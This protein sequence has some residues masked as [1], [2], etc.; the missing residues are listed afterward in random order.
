VL[1]AAAGYAVAAV[2]LG[3]SL[4]WTAQAVA[5]SALAGVASAAGSVALAT[6]LLPVAEE[7]AGIDT[8]LKLLEWSD[9]N[10]P[11]M[12]RLSLEAPGTYAHTIAMANLVEAACNA[13]GANGL[14]GRV[15]TY[16]HDIGKLERPQYFVENQPRGRN[17]HDKLKP[18]ASAGIIRGHVRE[19]LELAAQHKLPRAVRAFITEHHGT[20]RIVYFYEKARERPAGVA[21]RRG[22]RV[23]RSRAAPKRRC[24]LATG[25]RRPRACCRPVGRAFR[26]SS[27][28]CASA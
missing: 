16:Y 25:S 19:G 22:V 14:L 26:S 27:R 28:P 11:L 24:M 7:A 10:R 13:I 18:S 15:G 20:N 1:A 3:L 9:L 17:P 4:G 23:P 2:A 21:Q 12:Q 5:V 6:A 8:Y